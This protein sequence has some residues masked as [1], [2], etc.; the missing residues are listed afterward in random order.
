MPLWLIPGS[1]WGRT[2]TKRPHALA[3][4]ER[5]A[6]CAL[7]RVSGVAK[8]VCSTGA[9]PREGGRAG[10][11]LGSYDRRGR[12]TS[13]FGAAAYLGRHQSEY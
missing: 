2:T 5:C 10:A 4:L 9:R 8:V 6:L 3:N 13:Q 1:S 7:G 11:A 12:R